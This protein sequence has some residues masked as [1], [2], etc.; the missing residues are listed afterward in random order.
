MNNFEHVTEKNI[1][2]FESLEGKELVNISKIVV[3]HKSFNEYLAIVIFLA[4][5]R[6]SGIKLSLREQI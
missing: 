3:F 2:T 1:I 6:S 4:Q 5:H